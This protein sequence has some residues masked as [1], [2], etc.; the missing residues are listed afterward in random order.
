MNTSVILDYI[1]ELSTHNNR[2]WYH[3]HKQE[4]RE[5]NAQFEMLLQELILKIGETEKPSGTRFNEDRR[6]AYQRRGTFPG[7]CKRY[8]YQNEAF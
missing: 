2:E 6:R 5:A 3:A 8:F 4:Y 1:S 7:I